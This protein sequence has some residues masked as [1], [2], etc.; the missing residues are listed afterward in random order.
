[1]TISVIFFAMCVGLCIGG[2]SRW[3]AGV[4]GGGLVIISPVY[5][6]Q[7]VCVLA[8]AVLILSGLRSRR[9]EQ[10]TVLESEIVDV[11]FSVEEVK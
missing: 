1:M 8:L 7:I 10:C 3:E 11:K 4:M 9:I 6:S 2:C 5:I